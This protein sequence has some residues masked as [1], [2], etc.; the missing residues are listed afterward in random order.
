MDK[1]RVPLLAGIMASSLIRDGI[2]SPVSTP[3][4]F[5]GRRGPCRMG[6]G[7]STPKSKRKQQQASR[8]ANR[9]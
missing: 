1:H 6:K 4:E 5:D 2:P 3:M 7:R 9:R 8:K